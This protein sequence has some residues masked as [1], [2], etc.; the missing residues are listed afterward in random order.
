MFKYIQT[1]SIICKS[2]LY[3]YKI[4]AKQEWVYIIIMGVNIIIVGC[5]LLLWGCNKYYFRVNIIILGVYY[6]FGV[7]II[8]HHNIGSYQIHHHHSGHS[9]HQCSVPLGISVCT[10][11]HSYCPL[12]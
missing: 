3:L 5:V 7:Y 2:K 11:N 8:Q 1:R 9:V 6:Y 12:P 10:L 4:Q